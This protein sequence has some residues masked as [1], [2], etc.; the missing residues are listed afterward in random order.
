MQQEELVPLEKELDFA[1]N[2]LALQHIRFEEGLDYHIDIDKNTPG[3]LPPLSLQLLL[4]NAIKHNIASRQSPLRIVLRLEND[5]L[6]VEN[7]FQPKTTRPEESAGIGLSNIRKR[8]ELLSNRKIAVS[9]E[10]NR[11]IVR[12]PILEMTP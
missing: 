10:G 8:Y 3:A 12:L 7:N 2:F 1:E 11:F 4:E 9:S 5:E 6:I